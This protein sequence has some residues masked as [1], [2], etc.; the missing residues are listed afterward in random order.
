MPAPVVQAYY[1]SGP[2]PENGMSEC[3]PHRQ[4]RALGVAALN[5]GLCDERLHT[6][7]D[8]PL[9]GTCAVDTVIRG[10]NDEVLGCRGDVQLG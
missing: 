10:I 4:G 9:D 5:D 8:E 7:L 2:D 6:A 1:A 3:R